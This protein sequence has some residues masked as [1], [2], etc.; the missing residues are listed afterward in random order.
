[1]AVVTLLTDF[2]EKDGYPGIMQGVIYSIAPECRVVDLSHTV[3]PQGIFEGSLA[4]LR[5]LPYFPPGSVHVGVVDPGVGTERRPIAARLGEQFFVGP[6]NGLVTSI[7]EHT[8]RS[9]GQVAFVHLDRPEFWL[10]SV[11]KSFHGRDIFAPVGAHLANG[12]PLKDIGSHIEQV[13]RLYIPLPTPLDKGWSG[14]V[15]HVDH[16][17]NVATNIRSNHLLA[18]SAF[19]IKLKDHT[20]DRFFNS[21]GD[22]EEGELIAIIDSSGYLSLAVVNGSAADM[23]DTQSG[24]TIEVINQHG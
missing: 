2:G 10:P 9:G 18:F 20:I 24:D 6:D 14:E 16:F 5:A 19:H 17:G 1:M 21:Y 23:M 22:A 7:L 11:S 15:I 12:V 3:H 8:E 4:L 13:N